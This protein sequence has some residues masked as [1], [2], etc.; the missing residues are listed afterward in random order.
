[1]APEQTGTQNGRLSFATDVYG[2]G[3]TL[4]RLLTQKPPFVGA[5]QQETYEM[6][7]QVEATPPRVLRPSVSKDLET[8]CLKC[9]EKEPRRRYPSARE[10][11]DDLHRFLEG[12]PVVARPSRDSKK[13][14]DGPGT[15]RSRGYDHRDRC[16]HGHYSWYCNLVHQ[17]A[18]CGKNN[19]E[20]QRIVIEAERKNSHLAKL[21]GI[22]SRIRE[23]AIRKPPNWISDN[24]N[25]FLE[26]ANLGP[27]KEIS[28]ELRIKSYKQVWERS[29]RKDAVLLDNFDCSEASW[30]N[31]GEILA[32]GGNKALLGQVQIRLFSG[33]PLKEFKSLHFSHSISALTRLET[34]GVR[35][36]LFSRDGS[37][38]YCGSRS[39]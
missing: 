24:E 20:K 8:I 11:A 2:I 10:L 23:K 36:L 9:L 39:A 34:D 5:N 14:G 37:Q 22:T 26:A 19:Q 3:A 13:R 4:Y 31:D 38:L 25:D 32:I 6:V 15:S 33:T 27:S 16:R 17:K 1:M 29:L 21:F 28:A 18:R 7:R 30:S 12:K 35:S